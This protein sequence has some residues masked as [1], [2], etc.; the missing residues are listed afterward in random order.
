MKNEITWGRS[1]PDS[2]L[3]KGRL[4]KRSV[5]HEGLWLVGDTVTLKADDKGILKMYQEEK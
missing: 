2:Y 5:H 4:I 3:S 1:A